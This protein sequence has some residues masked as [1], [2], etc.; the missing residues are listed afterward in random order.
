M[1]AMVNCTPSPHLIVDPV[2]VNILLKLPLK[3]RAPHA[4]HPP[5]SLPSCALPWCRLA[6]PFLSIL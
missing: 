2:A 5:F 4:P 1:A 3:S 6:L